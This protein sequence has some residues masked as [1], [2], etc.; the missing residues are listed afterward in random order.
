MLI[1]NAAI[2]PKCERL[3]WSYTEEMEDC[4][5]VNLIAPLKLTQALKELLKAAGLAGG[6]DECKVKNSLIVNITSEL[7]SVTLADTTFLKHGY[8]PYRC[9]KV[10]TIPNSGFVSRLQAAMMCQCGLDFRLR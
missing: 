4:Y 9:A 3:D 2:L 5:A 6:G 1:N 10:E 8:L 7:G